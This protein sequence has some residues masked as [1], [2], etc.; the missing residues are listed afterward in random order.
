MH[1]YRLDDTSL[2]YGDVTLFPEAKW[3]FNSYVHYEFEEGRLDEVGGYLEHKFT[4]VGLRLGGNFVPEYFRDDGSEQEDEYEFM[5]EFWLTA[6]P[7]TIMGG[8]ASTD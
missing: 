4:C 3:S 6:F 5:I 1:R 2:L 7:E 8:T